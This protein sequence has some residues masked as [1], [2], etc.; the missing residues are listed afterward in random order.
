MIL[1]L[2]LLLLFA[3]SNAYLLNHWYP[4]SPY[5]NFDFSKPQKINVLDKELVVWVKNE[6]II[7]QDNTCIHRKLLYQ[8]DI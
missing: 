1:F 3:S 5:K 2:L 6:S 7:V 4:I 8:R